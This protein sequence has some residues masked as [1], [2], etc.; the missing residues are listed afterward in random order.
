[1]VVVEPEL[2]KQ[3]NRDSV[4]FTVHWSP[5]LPLEKRTVIGKI[6]SR[7]GLFEVYKDTGAHCPEII[8]RSYAYYGG[9]RNTLRGMIDVDRPIPLNGDVLDLRA[10][11]FVRYC[12]T[13]SADDMDDVMFFFGEED[14]DHSGRYR[15]V[16]VKE[17]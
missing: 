16:Y 11:H 13:D 17:I 12:M 10:R 4:Y 6:P 8:G 7:A 9:L 14:R 15:F 2:D 5:F 3:T 1:M